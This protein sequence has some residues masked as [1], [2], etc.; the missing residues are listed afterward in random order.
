MEAV[1]EDRMANKRNVV[2]MPS[3]SSRKEEAPPVKEPTRSDAIQLM[4]AKRG[5]L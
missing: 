1:M 2:Q 4:K 3:A 5:Q